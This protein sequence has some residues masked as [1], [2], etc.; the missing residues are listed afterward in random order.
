MKDVTLLAIESS[1]DETAVAVVRNGKEILSSVVNTQIDVHTQ[2][3]GVVPE[4][5]SRIHVENISIVIKEALKRSG[6]TMD[7]IDGIAFT[8]G[9][10]L[11]GSLHVGVL[12]AKTLA[13]AYNKPLIPVH[14]LTGHIYANAFVD[15]LKFPLLAL[16]VSGGHTEL[17]LMNEDYDF[18][19]IGSTQDDAI[20]E[21][22][23]K[24]GRVLGLPYPGGPKIDKLAK[25][26]Q[27][28]Y[29]LPIPKTEEPLDFSF[30]GLK[31]AVMQLMNRLEKQGVEL[32]VEDMCASFQTTALE[33]LWKRVDTAL[34][35][36]DVRQFILAGGVAANSQLR[37][38]TEERIP[39]DFPNVSYI[40]PPLAYC[41]DNGAMIGA[42]GYIA[43]IKGIRC[44]YD[45]EADPSLEMI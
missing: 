42:S 4:V 43:Y 30:S 20:G 17:V 21:A 31:S 7:D 34:R 38:M 23:D 6:L 36:Y 29:H 37:K 18:N 13:L 16:V 35:Q 12:A 14:H 32:K 41:T 22:Y 45:A 39:R 10:G 24:V 25:E 1:C 27:P 15:E 28:I 33:S 11:I 3:G 44:G 5:A 2:Y 26:G 40:I 9:P 8:I 19:I